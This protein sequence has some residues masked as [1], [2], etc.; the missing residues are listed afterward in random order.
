MRTVAGL[1]SGVCATA[2]Y[3]LTRLALVNAFALRVQ[4]FEAIPL[5]GQLLLGTQEPSSAAELLGIS[6]HIL[7]GAGLGAAFVIVAGA[8]GPLAGIVWA[9]VL[10][11]FMVALYPGWLD[12][13]ARNEFIGVSAAHLAYGATLGAVARRLL[14]TGTSER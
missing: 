3:D 2:V 10:E 1:A 13:R 11:L 14:R 7:N 12:I 4:P 8:R 6:Y 5:F 9:V